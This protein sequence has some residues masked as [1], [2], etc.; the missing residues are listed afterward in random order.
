MYFILKGANF[1]TSNIGKITVEEGKPGTGGGTGGSTTST[2]TFTISPT[3][4]TATVKLTATGYT[5]SGK[6]I[7]VPGGTTVSYTISASGYVTVNG[8]KQVWSTQTLPVTLNK[9]GASG[10]SGGGNTPVNP[11]SGALNV[12][13]TT[14]ASIAAPDG[15]DLTPQ[16]NRSRTNVI[17]VADLTGDITSGGT[18]S[19]FIISCY[20]SSG[21]YI[22]Q[23][24]K[25]DINGDLV[26][27][28]GQWI[29][30][31]TLISK[32]LLTS[33]GASTIRMVVD[34]QESGS[35]F[36]MGG[37][38]IATTDSSSSGSGSETA[39]YDY[40]FVAGTLTKEHGE[41]TSGARVRT[42]EYF[43][44][45]KLGTKFTVNECRF[46]VACYTSDKK[47]L[48]QYNAATNIL[49]DTCLTK[50][51]FNSAGVEVVTATI[52]SKQ[53]DI[54]EN[55]INTGNKGT[56]AYVR[57]V[58]ETPGSNPHLYVDGVK[59]TK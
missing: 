32:T 27:G 24:N 28:T 56:V 12:V 21:E 38:V 48:G 58:G 3:P 11:P 15:K 51:T 45:S 59:L 8:S 9:E 30:K 47:Y 34:S 36:I 13:W 6:S 55:A 46:I 18:A 7:T 42:N 39:T 22:G 2:Y 23:I 26:I 25:T 37:Q 5:Q 54:L 50:A 19:R 31:G 52:F 43:E 10:G 40:P 33:K 4:S 1:S 29:A 49:D 53:A 16:S 35:T 57:F 14:K 20:N 17:R 41:A 44:Q